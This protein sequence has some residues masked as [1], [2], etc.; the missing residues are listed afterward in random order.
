MESNKDYTENYAINFL[1]YYIHSKANRK[2]LN[3]NLSAEEY[4]K[5]FKQENEFKKNIINEKCKCKR[6]TFTRS[7]DADFNCLCG[8]CGNPI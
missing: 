3:L 8:K 5:F 1:N 4:L 7:V 6:S 2:F